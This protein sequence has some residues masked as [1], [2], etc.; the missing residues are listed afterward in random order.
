MLFW[1]HFCLFINIWSEIY[2]HCHFF[3]FLILY[4]Y[5]SGWTVS[6]FISLNW[7]SKR[8][9]LSSS[10]FSLVW[11]TLVM[12]LTLWRYQCPPQSA[13][14]WL[15]FMPQN[16]KKK[17]LPNAWMPCTLTFL[18][19]AA[20]QNYNMHE[21]GEQ[22]VHYFATLPHHSDFSASRLH[23]KHIPYLSGIPLRQ[24]RSRS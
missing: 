19:E 8:Y 23:V 7:R 2:K 22:V 12:L 18:E 1:I 24:R 15:F 4:L 6:E 13:F 10:D 14:S 11:L 20:A 3:C 17:E 9:I 21:I 16:I 5:V